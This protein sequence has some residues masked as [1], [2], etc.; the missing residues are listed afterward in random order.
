MQQMRCIINERGKGF[1]TQKQNTKMI[2]VVK[3]CCKIVRSGIQ[4]VLSEI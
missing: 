4:K 3:V 2:S 1:D